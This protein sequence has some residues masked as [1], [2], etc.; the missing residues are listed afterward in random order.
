MYLFLS[1][2]RSC[3]P[4]PTSVS[5][6]LIL[7][8]CGFTS[9]CSFLWLV[10]QVHTYTHTYTQPGHMFLLGTHTLSSGADISWHI[11]TM[12]HTHIYGTHT[13]LLG[14]HPPSTKHTRH[15]TNI[16]SSRALTFILTHIRPY[17]THTLLYMPAT[18]THP[19]G[20]AH[21]YSTHPAHRPCKHRAHKHHTP[22][23]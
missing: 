12:A 1:V 14:I 13:P 23:I 7:G 10:T 18:H 21:T 4:Q 11:H 17:T 5:P 16:P 3:S 22:F 19:I 8:H 2:I 6:I 9:S 15:G 20:I